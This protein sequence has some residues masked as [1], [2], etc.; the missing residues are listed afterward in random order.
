MVFILKWIFVALSLGLME[1]F[2]YDLKDI[3]KAVG[4]DSFILKTIARFNFGLWKPSE[5]DVFTLVRLVIFF[6]LVDCWCIK[7]FSILAVSSVLVFSFFHDGMYYFTRHR[8][9]KAIYSKG[10]FDDGKG[11]N[12][13]SLNL[14]LRTVLCGI[15]ISILFLL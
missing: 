9:N 14:P 10:F 11:T 2:M 6:C 5:H 12:F 7:C 3:N 1:G 4:K 8:L 15:G 13:I